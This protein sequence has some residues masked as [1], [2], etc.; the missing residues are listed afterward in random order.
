MEN[1]TENQTPQNVALPLVLSTTREDAEA[2]SQGSARVIKLI[3]FAMFSVIVIGL[4]IALVFVAK[5]TQTRLIVIGFAA[6]IAAADFYL[7]TIFKKQREN[8]R[9]LL[10]SDGA[11]VLVVDQYGIRVGDKA[12]PR[13]RITAVVYRRV[14]AQETSSLNNGA[15]AY[16][17]AIGLDQV[18]TLSPDGLAVRPRSAG[19]TG[20][21]SG[22]DAGSLAF[23]FTQHLSHTDLPRFLAAAEQ[24]SA[25]GFPVGEI[26][27]AFWVRI[28]AEFGASREHIKNAATKYA[29]QA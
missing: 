9:A 13:E 25:G 28:Q 14:V 16:E 21:E 29:P 5:D 7:I 15:P 3:G 18:S 11:T 6:A 20:L 23:N 10:A 1:I 2:A 24:V 4:I 8:N 12:L 19:T 27:N 22:H 17:I 26:N